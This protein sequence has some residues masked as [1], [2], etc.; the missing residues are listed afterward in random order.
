MNALILG[1]TVL[2]GAGVAGAAPAAVPA[3]LP[4]CPAAT[5]QSDELAYGLA[6]SADYAGIRTNFYLQATTPE[7]VRV[8]TDPADAAVCQRLQEYAAQQ[9]QAHGGSLSGSTTV[10]YRAGTYYYAIVTVPLVSNAVT[11]DGGMQVRDRFVPVYVFD[12]NLNAVV[13][14]AL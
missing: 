6:T 3:M 5:E 8:L 7:N 11:P 1:F 4:Y 14:V 13:A 2:A 10:F 9:A 12:S